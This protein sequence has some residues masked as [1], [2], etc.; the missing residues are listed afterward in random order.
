M[1]YM[2]MGRA[3][4]AYQALGATTQTH[5]ECDAAGLAAQASY[6]AQLVNF[7]NTWKNRDGFFYVADAQAILKAGLALESQGQR[8]LDDV[9]T[10]Y[11]ETLSSSMK[12]G[13]DQA[14]DDLIAVG[15]TAIDFASAIS[16]AIGKGATVIDAPGLRNWVIDAISASGQAAYIAA[17]MDCLLVDVSPFIAILGG[18]LTMLNA[19]ITVAKTAAVVVYKTGAVVYKTTVGT[20]DFVASFVKYAPYA[21]AAYGLVWLW[22]KHQRGA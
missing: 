21:A 3:R 15:K 13:R 12:T 17:Y 5:P 6:D 1:S 8:M 7:K 20:L 9:R 10:K 18:M 22:Q 16:T 2:P 11:G 14:F 4:P 19:L